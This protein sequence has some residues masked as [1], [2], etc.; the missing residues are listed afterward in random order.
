MD[1]DFEK[2]R[3]KM[4]E[5]VEGV[6]AGLSCLKDGDVERLKVVGRMNGRNDA[7]FAVT[8]LLK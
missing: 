2:E 7:P 8:P 1:K 5:L 6:D 4:D 3:E